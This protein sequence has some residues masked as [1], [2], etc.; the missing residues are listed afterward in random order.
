[1][2]IGKLSDIFVKNL[3]KRIVF[4]YKIWYNESNGSCGGAVPP[5][6]S[7]LRKGNGNEYG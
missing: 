1:M 7:F 4:S 3:R 5:Q 2:F 6:R